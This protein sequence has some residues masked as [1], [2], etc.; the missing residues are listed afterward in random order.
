MY[1]NWKY[2]KKTGWARALYK[3][4]SHRKKSPIFILPFKLIF[5]L[6]I[7]NKYINMASTLASSFKHSFKIQ[8]GIVSGKGRVLLTFKH[9]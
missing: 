5:T 7:P 3:Q 6:K 8:G 1:K 4:L 2:F 9:E